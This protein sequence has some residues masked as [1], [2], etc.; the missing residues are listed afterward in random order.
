MRRTALWLLGA[1]LVAVGL[2]PALAR[3]GASAQ[4][5]AGTIRIAPATLSVA[6]GGT[7]TAEVWLEGGGG[8]Y[9]VELRLA[10]D[11][12]LV[13]VPSGQ[14]T[15][16]WD[17]LSA[18][19]HI[20]VKN[21]AGWC[22]DRSGHTWYGAWYAVANVSPAPA[23]SG[24]GRIC[25]LT[26]EGVASGTVALEVLVA[27]GATAG[28]TRL[29]PAATGAAV[30]VLPMTATAM[31]S[32]MASATRTAAA[33][34]TGTPTRT[35]TATRT[36]SPTPRP[37]GTTAPPAAVPAA[38][39]LSPS[40]TSAPS[41]TPTPSRTPTCGATHF[42]TTPPTPT[43]C[44]TPAPTPRPGLAQGLAALV[45]AGAWGAHLVAFVG[46]ASLM[47]ALLRLRRRR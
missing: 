29:A 37:T 27:V 26:L 5:E 6:T 4:G 43:P 8:Y 1:G 39:T 14:V 15:P 19:D 25:A 32:R 45:E 46:G 23:F 13:R 40:A 44:A 35:A 22:D 33:T 28:G 38:A 24:G 47:A 11:P 34:R 16:L 9:G 42:P 10:L 36:P 7:A 31:P 17:V 2:W 21:Q 41:G 18:R 12:A 30:E 3:G 20:I